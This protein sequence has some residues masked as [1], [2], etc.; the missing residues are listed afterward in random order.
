MVPEYFRRP[1]L[2]A[3]TRAAP[4]S[5]AGDT[6]HL[7]SRS[8]YLTMCSRGKKENVAA[9]EAE[10]MVRWS[11]DGDTGTGHWELNKKR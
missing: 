8:V 6:R 11:H 2:E 5:S 4:S 7:Q 9:E 1:G 3:G 10:A